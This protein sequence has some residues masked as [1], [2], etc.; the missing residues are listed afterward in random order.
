MSYLTQ[1]PDFPESD[2]PKLP[3]GFVDH[4]WKNE[5]CPCFMNSALGLAVFIDYA[6]ETKREFQGEEGGK[7]F[8]VHSI[9]DSGAVI[10][11]LLESDE[12]AAVLQF[13]AEQ[14]AATHHC[15]A[16][17]WRGTESTARE[18]LETF[19]CDDGLEQRAG[20]MCPKCSAPLDRLMTF[21][22]FQATGFD[23]PDI[24]EKLKDES[25]QGS[26][27][28]IY[29]GSLYIEK[30]NDPRGPWL[31]MIGR[32]QPCGELVDVEWELYSW[33]RSEGYCAMTPA[34]EITLCAEYQA[35]CDA[36]KYPPMSAD[37]L[38]ISLYD[39][40]SVA[41]HTEGDREWLSDFIRRWE[42][43]QESESR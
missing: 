27:G 14:T 19:E 3:A 33:A 21:A 22:E 6:D 17:D 4:S 37:E 28:R 10:S 43:W 39:G 30:W 24:G 16:C 2:M 41:Q 18:T 34:T 31:T 32:E 20:L 25:L 5:A 40:G 29:C 9:D 12:W 42:A 26:S 36:R 13:I 38:L 8:T 7:R 35:W 1:F 23:C 15:S 11:V